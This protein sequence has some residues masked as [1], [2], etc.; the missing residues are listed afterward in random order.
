MNVAKPMWF[1]NQTFR[2]FQYYNSNIGWIIIAKPF[3]V[4]NQNK[5]K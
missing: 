5:T 2:I 4:S 1:P 3:S